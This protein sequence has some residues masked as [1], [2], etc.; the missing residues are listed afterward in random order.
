VKKLLTEATRGCNHPKKNSTLTK[1]QDSRPRLRAR[2]TQDQTPQDRDSARLRSPRDHTRS[3][4]RASGNRPRHQDD[5]QIIGVFYCSP[6]IGIQA[7][8]EKK[9]LKAQ[10]H[11]ASMMLGGVALRAGN[12]NRPAGEI[13]TVGGRVLQCVDRSRV[14]ANTK[15][16]CKIKRKRP[17][18]GGSKGADPR[19]TAD[20]RPHAGATVHSS[21]FSH[22]E[23]HAAVT[24]SFRFSIQPRQ[25]ENFCPSPDRPC[26]AL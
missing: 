24:E 11:Q 7:A 2:T 23:N 17:L 4:E 5:N 19:Q 15:D 12:L 18:S 1:S 20:E 26:R 3:L 9:R 21:I 16:H 22:R 8:R 14:A 6:K 13:P 25:L 10:R